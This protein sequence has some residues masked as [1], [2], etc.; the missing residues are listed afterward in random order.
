[1]IDEF[2][3]DIEDCPEIPCCSCNRLFKRSQVTKVSL[4]DNLG[5]NVWPRLEYYILQKDP[6]VTQ[7]LLYM[8]TIC[9]SNIRKETRCVLNGLETVPV[10]KILDKLDS[11]SVQL[12]QRAKCYQTIVRLGT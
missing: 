4:S 7:D 10:P 6:N 9:K 12:V 2:E 11:L 1:M 8:C 3:K 5:I